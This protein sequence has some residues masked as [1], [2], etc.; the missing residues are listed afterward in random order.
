MNKTVTKSN[1]VF[2]L[3]F[4]RVIAIIGIILVHIPGIWINNLSIVGFK[5]YSIAVVFKV[6]GK[7]GVPIFLMLTGYLVLNKINNDKINNDKIINSETNNKNNYLDFSNVFKKIYK[8]ILIPMIFWSPILLIIA[9][10]ALNL[11]PNWQS[12]GIKLL[13]TYLSQ[14]WYVWLIIGVYLA[15]PILNEFVKNTKE[16]GVKYFIAISIVAS[17]IWIISSIIEYKPFYL[18]LTLFLGPFTYVILGYYLKIK[19]FKLKPK[20]LCLI[21]LTLFILTTIIY[22]LIEI[23]Y[24]RNIETFLRPLI[25]KTTVLNLDVDLI[26]MLQG[27][28]LFVFIQNL[29]KFKFKDIL[30]FKIVKLFKKLIESISKA[31]FGIYIVHYLFLYIIL[32]YKP[33]LIQHNP[34][35]MIPIILIAIFIPSYLLI[36][37]TSKIPIVNKLN[38]YY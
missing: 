24:G 25:N 2:F 33:F 28:S 8:R 22:S 36:I 4:L 3:D 5:F 21:S 1:R 20:T 6:L 9:H 17:I 12:F 13:T 30:R 11:F 31:S 10:F 32:S 34:L 38:G 16:E 37:I 19:K 35:L 18:D 15:L 27:F 29:S 7:F 14:Y 26:L 23:K